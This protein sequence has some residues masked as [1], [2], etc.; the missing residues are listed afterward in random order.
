MVAFHIIL[1]FYIFVF[2]L[3]LFVVALI[4]FS[5]YVVVVAKAQHCL[6]PT[7]SMLRHVHV[8]EKSLK[9]NI[10]LYVTLPS[11]ILNNT[12]S[13][14]REEGVSGSEDGGFYSIVG[15]IYNKWAKVYVHLKDDKKISKKKNF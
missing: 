14:F 8:D 12:T 2:F 4:V 9:D 15:G 13:I 6:I 10:S 3:F 11:Y 7:F 1:W 5:V